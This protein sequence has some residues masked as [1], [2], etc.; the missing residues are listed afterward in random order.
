MLHV[1][2]TIIPDGIAPCA[3]FTAGSVVSKAGLDV[4]KKIPTSAGNRTPVAQPVSVVTPDINRPLFLA[5]MFLRVLKK[6]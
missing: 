5:T 4:K 2:E 3:H 1:S 6:N